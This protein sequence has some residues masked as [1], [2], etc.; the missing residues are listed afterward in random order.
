M[1]Q[2][3]LKKRKITRLKVFRWLNLRS[4]K[5]NFNLL[6][7]PIKNNKNQLN[8]HLLLYPSNNKNQ[9]IILSWARC[10]QLRSKASQINSKSAIRWSRWKRNCFE[11]FQT[12]LLKR[13]SLQTLIKIICHISELVYKT[14]LIQTFHAITIAN[15]L[16]QTKL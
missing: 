5:N 2:I 6:I 13:L 12:I 7:Q 4:Q 1:Y 3:I 11:M 14:P 15:L 10:L 8:T 16:Y 9:N